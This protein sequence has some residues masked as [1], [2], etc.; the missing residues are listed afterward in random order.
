MSCLGINSPIPRNILLA[1]NTYFETTNVVDVIGS[2]RLLVTV[3]V[4]KSLVVVETMSTVPLVSRLIQH[5]FSH[6][7]DRSLMSKVQKKLFRL[8]FSPVICY[9]WHVGQCEKPKSTRGKLRHLTTWKTRIS[10]LP[11]SISQNRVCFEWC[12]NLRVLSKCYRI[13]CRL[14]W[15]KNDYD[16]HKK[17]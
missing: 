12:K 5:Y 2:C 16:S 4:H 8:E 3:I 6:L 7:L 1:N 14:V 9:I 15:T 13:R 17:L 10:T 11:Y